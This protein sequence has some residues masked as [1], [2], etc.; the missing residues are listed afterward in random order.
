MTNARHGYQP[1]YGHSYNPEKGRHA[2][3]SP[4][5]DVFHKYGHIIITTINTKIL[6]I[7]ITAIHITIVTIV[8]VQKSRPL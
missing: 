3:F 7:T 5:Q 1:S 2:R 6:N 4:V 8:Y